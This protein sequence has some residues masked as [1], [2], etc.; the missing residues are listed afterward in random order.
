MNMH[1][2][3]ETNFHYFILFHINKYKSNDQIN[4]Y[5]HNTLD[6]FYKIPIFKIM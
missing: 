2:I 6:K 1:Q 5:Y 3:I 4:S